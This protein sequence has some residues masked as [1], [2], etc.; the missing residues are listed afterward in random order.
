MKTLILSTENVR[1]HIDVETAVKTVDFVFHEQGAGNVSMPPKI[2]TDMSR[3]GHEA[4]CN[5]MPAYIVNRQIGGIKWVGGF[6]ENPKNSLPYIMGVVL[7][8]DP[9]NGQCISMLDGRLISDHRTGAM[10]AV[11]AQHLAV[12]PLVDILVVGAGAQGEMAMQCLHYSFP[13]AEIKLFDIDHARVRAKKEKFSDTS[14]GEK[15]VPVDNLKEAAQASSLIVLLTT[16]KKPF[17]ADEWIR[18]GCTVLGMGS[19]PQIE[20]TFV[21]SADKIITDS[22]AQ[23]LHRGELPPLVKEKR[24]DSSFIHAEIN[25]VLSGSKTGR[26]SN[27]ER[28]LCLL[29][30]IGAHDVCLGHVVYQ[31]AVEAGDGVSVELQ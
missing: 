4:W 28:I 10:A 18:P 6:G 23:A 13:N 3:I 12:Q 24:V 16:A 7:L 31:R 15:I 26:E 5:A 8:T 25:E 22:L 21:F 14:L 17:L 19:Y 27:T 30:G 29:I 9:R 11:F 2:T 20:E 1:K